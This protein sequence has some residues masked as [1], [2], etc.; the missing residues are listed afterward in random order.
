MRGLPDLPIHIEL[1]AFA[2]SGYHDPR[3]FVLARWDDRYGFPKVEARAYIEENLKNS[4]AL[5]LLDALD[6]TVIGDLVN[7]AEASYMR[8]ADLITQLA[9]RYHQCPIVVTARKA[10][11]QQRT[12]LSGFTE[13]EVLD[14][15]QE[16]IEQFVRNWFDCSPTSH[17]YANAADLNAKLSRNS[18][19]LTLASNPLLLSLIVIVYE[20]QLDLPDRRTELYKRCLDTLLTKW[21]A[22]REIRRRREF[23][24]EQKLQLLEEI[25]WHFHKQGRRYLPEGDLLSLIE[26]FLPA[27]N[28]PSS[29]NIQ[30]LE[31]IAAEMACL[32]SK[33]STGTAYC[34]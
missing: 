4:N 1:N 18:R 34:I 16:D 24:P 3:D 23:K 21:D 17:Q 9:T 28:L 25:A 33:R 22:S 12:R 14:F 15:R 27:I 13:L 7:E 32:K 5:L 8:V 26:G 2:S 10:G 19:L 11:Y 31:E 29:Q 30:V 6:E 20:D